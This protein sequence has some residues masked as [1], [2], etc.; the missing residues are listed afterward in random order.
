MRLHA[1]LVLLLVASVL[2]VAPAAPVAAA[3]PA[4][5]RIAELLAN[6]DPLQ[7]QRE[8]IELWNPT[9]ATVDLA[10]WTVHDAPTAS[11]SANEFTFAPFQLAPNA[12]VVVWSN[13]TPDARGPSWSTS[14][15]KT[16]ASGSANEFTF[17]P[18]QLAPNA[19]VVV[20]SNGTP[21]A[22]DP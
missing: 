12:R 7:G 1:A 16:V 17:A 3:N 14:A 8:F 5:L 19:R 9:N 2:A 18:F 10:G 21:D 15:G 20:W 22:R 4:A 11:G 13:G 6:P